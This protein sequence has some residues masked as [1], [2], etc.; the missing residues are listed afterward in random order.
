MYNI[1]CKAFTLTTSIFN[2]GC[3][4]V[5]V[6]VVKETDKAIQLRPHHN[7]NNVRGF[8]NHTVWLP[9][10]WLTPQYYNDNGTQH[11]IGYEVPKAKHFLFSGWQQHFINCYSMTA[12]YEQGAEY[13]MNPV[14]C[15]D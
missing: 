14:I 1:K 6:D 7:P 2:G 13:L 15:N 10:A 9:K 11:F 12:Y 3:H 8:A 5:N 4:F